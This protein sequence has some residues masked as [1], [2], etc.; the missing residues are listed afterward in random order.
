MTKYDTLR[1]PYLLTS[2]ERSSSQSSWSYKLS[3][4]PVPIK[5]SPM[6]ATWALRQ[7]SLPTGIYNQTSL[8]L[9]LIMTHD[10]IFFNILCCHCQYYCL[11]PSYSVSL[12]FWTLT[13]CNFWFDL[14]YIYQC[15]VHFF[16]PHP[17]ILLWFN[18]LHS[19]CF[20]F[21][22]FS[23]CE[24]NSKFPFLHHQWA[25]FLLPSTV[26]MISFSYWAFPSFLPLVGQ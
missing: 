17:P 19:A 4:V 16:S 24:K 20:A 15:V 10:R 7:L 9:I 14:M 2:T 12:F 25:S 3:T 6:Y 8:V 13:L 26:G 5:H 11:L 21:S 18:I 22:F 1:V 23:Q